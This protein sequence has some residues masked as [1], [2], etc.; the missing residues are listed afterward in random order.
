[1]TN[2]QSSARANV[3]LTFLVILYNNDH[4][5]NGTQTDRLNVY[6]A[7]KILILKGNILVGFFLKLKL[8]REKR[9]NLLLGNGLGLVPW[10]FTDWRSD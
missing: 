2:K 9:T 5:E 1:M 3:N 8:S 10:S 7:K 6:N 4:N